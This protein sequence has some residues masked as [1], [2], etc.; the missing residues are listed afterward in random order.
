MALFPKAGLPARLKS[1]TTPFIK[2]ATLCDRNLCD[3][4]LCGL[5][6][7]ANAIFAAFALKIF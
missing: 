5:C 6:T 4:N 3:Y 2:K 7:F 1:D